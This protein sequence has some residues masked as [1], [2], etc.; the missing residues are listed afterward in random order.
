M[1]HR[2]A[3]SVICNVICYACVSVIIIPAISRMLCTVA[4]TVIII[5][6]VRWW[7]W[8]L[9]CLV[10]GLKA[11]KS[12]LETCQCQGCGAGAKAILN[13]WSWSQRLG[14][15]CSFQRKK[16]F[17]FGDADFL[18]DVISAGL[19]GH[20]GPL[21]LALGPNCQMVVF[22]WRYYWKLGYN[23]SLLIL[24]M[25]CWDFWIKSYDIK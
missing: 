4:V 23:P 25:T 21:H 7:L 13:G 9:L 20:L 1:V 17:W 24:W 18:S 6:N 2:R 19:S 22:R 16:F 11:V 12:F 3:L 10:L 8:A 5:I 15:S 14:K